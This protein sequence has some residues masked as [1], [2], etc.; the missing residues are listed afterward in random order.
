MRRAYI[1]CMPVNNPGRAR[2][3]TSW[4][5]TTKGMPASTGRGCR[6]LPARH[7]RTLHSCLGSQQHCLSQRRRQHRS[8]E[9]RPGQRIPPPCLGG[10]SQPAQPGLHD[11]Q[12]LSMGTSFGIAELS[13]RDGQPH[14]ARPSRPHPPGLPG[15]M[16][17][18]ARTHG[19]AR[20]PFP[21]PMRSA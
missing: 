8:Q 19:Q 18:S 5:V 9:R 2:W 20:T 7:Q 13:G 11:A 16:G 3:V 6:I 1:F 4:T 21:Y 15:R 10:L 14:P 12:A 17:R